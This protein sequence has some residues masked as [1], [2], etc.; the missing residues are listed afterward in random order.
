MKQEGTERI[1][2]FSFESRTNEKHELHAEF[3][4]GGNL[5][6]CDKD[7]II[8]DVAR[9]QRFRHRSLVPDEIYALP[10]M[11]GRSLEEVDLEFLS[12]S[13]EGSQ[14]AIR[15]FGRLVGT[16]RKFV[17]EIFFRAKVDPNIPGSDLSSDNLASLARAVKDLRQELEN[18]TRGYLLLPEHDEDQI[19]VDVCPFVPNAWNKEISDGSAELREYPSFS[20]ALDDAQ[21]EVLLLAKRRGASK[22][23][24]SKAEEL[25]SAIKK[26]ELA[27]EQNEKNSS[28]L[29]LLAKEF[30]ALTSI[31]IPQETIAKLQTMKIVEQD[32]VRGALRFVNEPRSFFS[33]FSTPR[34]IASR[35]FDEAKVLE[36][37]NRNIK[38][39]RSTL[40]KKK[41]ALVEQSVASE[42]RAAKRTSTERRARQWFERYRWFLTSDLRLAIGG[43]DST[44]NSV[45][46][47]KYLDPN[48][49]VFHADLHGSPFFVLKNNL[50]KDNLEQ[51]IEHELAQATASFS[52][53]W[54]DE[55]GSADSYW[56][57]PDQI[58]KSAPSGEYLPRGSFF[59][60]G[61]KNIVK[62]LRI[63]LALGLVTSDKI[64][65]QTEVSKSAL[66]LCGPE[67]SLAKYCASIVRIAP[68]KERGS[69][70]SRRIK[71]LLISKAKDSETKELAKKILLD[72]IIRVLPSGSY[73]IISEKQNG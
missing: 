61:K 3:F 43:R 44:S 70:V 29:R 26:Q 1:A 16:S 12:S 32:P 67:K 25:E 63:E 8:I 48:D 45:I 11:R 6:L 39:I 5:I 56:V 52:R 59:I 9:P 66:V 69:S 54:K 10:P 62:H 71:Q 40:L 38:S 19:D 60:E 24:R 46:I 7:Q 36:E 18:S 20:E 47:N 2:T 42:E 51:P 68:G 53:A 27:I 49:Y 58:K 64:P 72:D 14:P 30:M 22:E 31:E 35:L 17:E 65:G 33:S 4:S 37:S 34:A 23:I 41:E 57:R 55:L 13:K 15:W 50:Q 73:K 28:E 21:V